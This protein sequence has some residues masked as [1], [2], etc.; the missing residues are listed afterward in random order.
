MR[1]FVYSDWVPK[2]LNVNIAVDKELDLQFLKGKGLQSNERPFAAPDLHAR[3]A[4][5]KVPDKALMQ[6]LMSMG[7]S[8]NAATRACLAVNNANIDAA[9]AWIF[10]HMDDADLNSP[11]P[12]AA[13]KPSTGPPAFVVNPAALD[14]VLLLGF[15]KDR[16]V[17]ALQQTN[18]NAERAT[19]WLLNHMDEP[20]PS[21]SSGSSSSSSGAAAS[22]TA[23]AAPVDDRPPKY[24]LVAMVAHQGNS[25][26][27]GH[28]V[29]YIVKEGK[30]T[31]FN[32]SKVAHT[33]K[34]PLDKA[35][36]YFFRK[37][38]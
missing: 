4:E 31:V 3:A 12:E 18:N 19:D 5:K 9:S 13:P 23:P 26:G 37:I 16:C 36:I 7:F 14:Q 15:P 20:I 25:T 28:Y 30:W 22:S 24:R 11:I 1:R 29:A 2:K 10:E 17:H 35:Y 21:A 6:Q 34:P 27:H 8:S 32:D 38:G 33:D